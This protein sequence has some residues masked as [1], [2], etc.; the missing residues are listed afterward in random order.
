[1]NSITPT[2]HF[3]LGLSVVLCLLV[4]TAC[5][6]NSL[7]DGDSHDH[8]TLAT[9]LHGKAKVDVCH[10]NDEGGYH[11]INISEAAYDAH[12]AHGDQVVGSPYP[13]MLG[14]A[15]DDDCRP[16]QSGLLAKYYHMASWCGGNA[17]NPSSCVFPNGVFVAE[18]VED[19]INHRVEGGSFWPGTVNSDLFSA[20]WTGA[21]SPLYSE[22][23]TFCVAT[24]DGSRLWIDG[25]LV[26][27]AWWAQPTTE[28]CGQISLQAGERYALQME[29]FEDFGFATAELRWLSASQAKQI[30]PASAFLAP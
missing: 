13:G 6:S 27:D 22:N 15:F 18:R 3:T 12:I 14:Y 5:D 4:L 19:T 9:S 25:Q 16:T 1:M 7:I 17:A 29:F 24:D 21:V 2:R 26:I 10:L 8:L 23:Y 20:R 11:K 30:V 28:H